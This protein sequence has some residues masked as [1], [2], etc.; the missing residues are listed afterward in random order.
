MKR[1]KST[2]RITV[3]DY[4][5]AARNGARLA[6][7]ELLGDGF[8]SVDRPHRSKKVYSRKSKHRTELE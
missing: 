8:R 4:L 3:K 5:K 1:K 2:K 7:R 6:Q